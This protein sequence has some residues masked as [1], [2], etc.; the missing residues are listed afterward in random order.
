MLLRVR[1]AAAEHSLLA[2][3]A[4]SNEND[5]PVGSD[6]AATKD[7]KNRRMIISKIVIEN[8]KSYAGVVEIGPLHKVATRKFCF[9]I[10]FDLY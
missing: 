4:P 6:N 5:P 3:S 2:M 9:S 10:M 8:F 1:V 7:T